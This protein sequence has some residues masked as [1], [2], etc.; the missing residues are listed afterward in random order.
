MSDPNSDPEASAMAA[1]MGFSNF[2]GKPPARKRKFNAATDAFVSGDELA[3]IDRGGKKGKGSGGNEVPL[4]KPRVL[5]V[6]SKATN[7]EEIA[8]DDEEEDEGPRYEDTSLPAPTEAYK[9]YNYGHGDSINEVEEEDGP[10][11]MDTSL[12]PPTENPEYT[13]WHEREGNRD[14]EGPRYMDTSL[15]PPFE[16][17]TNGGPAYEDTSLPPPVAS[18]PDDEAAEMQSRINAILASIQPPPGEDDTTQSAKSTLPPG[19]TSPT[20]NSTLR[21]IPP[22]SLGHNLPPKPSFTPSISSRGRGMSDAGSVTSASTRFSGGGRN[23]EWYL[24]YYDHSFNENP[25]EKLEQKL[26]LDP[27]G[28]WLPRPQGNAR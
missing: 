6:R 15:P 28:T 18:V 19:I 27:V 12:P 13:P 9:G 4:G 5:G 25:W 3:K 21:S 8:L 10:R 26:G 22:P 23:P 7:E 17:G 24:G 20:T 2:G 11:Y 1:M 14:E 16:H